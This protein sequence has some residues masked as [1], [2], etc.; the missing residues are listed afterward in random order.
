MVRAF[1]SSNHNRLMFRVRSAHKVK[2]IRRKLDA[3]ASKRFE[4]NLAHSGVISHVEVGVEGE[5][6]DRETSSYIHSSLI[7]GRNEEMEMVIESICNKD[8][9]KYDNCEI[10]VYGIW[11]MGGV[12]KSYSN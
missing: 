4:L 9:G 6:P 5:M 7:F 11:G 12:G 3:I 8:I 2:A 1:F 10:R